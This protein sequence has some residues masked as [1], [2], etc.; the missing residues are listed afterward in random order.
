MRQRP[1]VIVVGVSGPDGSGKSS[2]LRAMADVASERGIGVRHAYLYGCVLCRSLR[3]PNGLRRVLS[4]EGT[5]A[6][7]FPGHQGGA[8]LSSF[9]RVHALLDTMELAG[10]LAL[11]RW[12][13]GRLSCKTDSGVLL[14]TDRSPV[15][16]LVKH[17]P[18]YDSAVARLLRRLSQRYVVI[19]VLDAHERVL[20]RRDGE[21]SAIGL[22]RARQGYGRWSAGGER[23]LRLSTDSASLHQLADRVLRQLPLDD[24][25][26]LAEGSPAS[27]PAAVGAPKKV[28]AVDRE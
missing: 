13:A 6:L 5:V 22:Q 28:A 9:R 3:L 15:D 25:C 14:L 7:E 12:R 18:P 23:M 2:L 24:V 8:P 27:R 1:H 26:P 21:H 10:R 11:S 17:D 16:T 4:S 20:A 19:A